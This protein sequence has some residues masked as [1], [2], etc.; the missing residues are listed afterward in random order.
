MDD[1]VAATRFGAALGDPRASSALLR[2][3]A[4]RHGI[5]LQPASDVDLIAATI[6]ADA[7]LTAFNARAFDGP[8]RHGQPAVRAL[9]AVLLR[10]AGGAAGT[11]NLPAGPCSYRDEVI[12][13]AERYSDWAAEHIDDPAQALRAAASD[14][15]QAGALGTLAQVAQVLLLAAD[16]G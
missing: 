6:A 5:T 8:E 11:T 12:A 1:Q 9:A 15:A 7:W 16:D 2:A 13:L 14:L 4:A 10:A 3:L